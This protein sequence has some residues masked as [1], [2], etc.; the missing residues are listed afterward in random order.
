MGYYWFQLY[1]DGGFFPTHLTNLIIWCCEKLEALPRMHMVTTL[2]IYKCP[3]IVSL[4]EEGLSTNLKELRLG[5]MTICKQVF[6]WGLHRLSSLTRLTIIGDEF[7]DWQ[8]FPEEEDGKMMLLLPTSLTSLSIDK[9]PDIAFL[10]SKVFQN[11]S[12]LEELWIWKCPKLASLPENGLPPSLLHLWISECPVLKQNCK[13][14]KGH[15]VKQ[16]EQNVQKYTYLLPQGTTFR[17]WYLSS[18]CVYIY[19]IWILKIQP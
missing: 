7:E 8:S 12:S 3:S 18:L 10:S 4:P 1:S 16:R 6:E 13:K 9:F 14:G 17:N 15:C 11:L 19:A 5:G 2:Y